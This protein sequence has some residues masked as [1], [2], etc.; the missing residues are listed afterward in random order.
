MTK[1]HSDLITIAN[2]DLA[3]KLDINHEIKKAAAA[4]S[5]PRT[6]AKQNSSAT[7]GRTKTV[8]T[9]KQEIRHTI[10][11]LNLIR[12][13]LAIIF[14]G[15]GIAAIIN[16]DWNLAQR[17]TNN[18]LFLIGASLV[19]L[20]A[21]IFV[22]ISKYKKDLDFDILVGAQFTLDMVLAALITYSAGSVES[23]A[24]LLYLAVVAT[25]SVVL[26][27]KHALGLASGGI[28]LMFFEHFYSIWNGDTIIR[29]HYVLLVRYSLLILTASLLISYLAERIKA[30]EFKG[31]A[32]GNQ[33]IEDYLIAEETKALKA[34]LEQTQGNK[35]KAAK[36]LGMKFRSF[37]YKLTKY[38][39]D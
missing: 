2:A 15:V 11:I 8:V 23:N 21:G 5:M 16:P 39:I 38:N 9:F 25:G 12:G 33:T 32:P 4:N 10:F 29:P 30:A 31:F 14:V 13:C 22:Y 28:I 27:R 26:P 34:A 7:S 3:R 1:K 17:L 18:K 24:A 6:E 35:T 19:L 37:R 36:L 20:S